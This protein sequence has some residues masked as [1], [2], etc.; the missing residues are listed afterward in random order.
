MAQTTEM[1]RYFMAWAEG[2]GLSW[3]QKPVRL[4]EQQ[5]CDG[6]QVSNYR[7]CRFLHVWPQGELLEA[8]LS[9]RTAKD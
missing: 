1:L 5:A 2:E 6:L 9:W 8:V 7:A 4:G 3:G